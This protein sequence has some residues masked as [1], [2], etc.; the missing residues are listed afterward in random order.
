MVEHPE[1][2]FVRVCL[3]ALIV[4]HRKD[5]LEVS[6]GDQ[7]LALAVIDAESVQ[8]VPH[9]GLTERVALIDQNTDAVGR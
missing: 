3:L 1:A 7:V 8:G 2:Q 6:Q 4:E 5:L 9:E